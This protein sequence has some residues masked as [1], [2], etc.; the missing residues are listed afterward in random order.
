MLVYWRGIINLDS[1]IFFSTTSVAKLV[2]PVFFCGH[3]MEFLVTE[4][5]HFTL[6]EMALATLLRR[7][8]A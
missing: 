8:C 4:V 1:N 7:F 3:P 6:L 2:E 5:K